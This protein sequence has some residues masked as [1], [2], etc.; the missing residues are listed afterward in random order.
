MCMSEKHSIPSLDGIRALAILAVV[1]GHSESPLFNH[2][3][4]DPFRNGSLGVIGFFVLSGFLITGILVRETDRAGGISLKRFY[5]RRA[6]R[7]FPAFY[8]YLIVIAILGVLRHVKLDLTSWLA[9]AT[10][11][12]N[13]VLNTSSYSLGQTWSLSLEE[14]FYLLW[15][16]CLVF[17]SKKTCFRIAVGSILLSPFSR[18]LTYALF[19]AF[20]GHINMMLHTHID[21]ILTGAALALA[22]NL[23]LFAK[24]RVRLANAWF[25]LPIGVY[26]AIHPMLANLYRGSFALPVGMTLD[27]IAW[28]IFVLHVTRFPQLPVG[29]FL[30]WA[31]I[32][33][34]GRISYSVY[35]WQQLF[36]GENQPNAFP[37]NL[38]WIFLCAEGSYW[39]IEQPF[40]RLRDRVVRSP[41][42][43]LLPGPQAPG[44]VAAIEQARN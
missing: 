14:Q 15:P 38:I 4:I 16:L 20:R 32:A 23:G 29:K 8:A 39:L 21:A 36:T 10:Y 22:Q 30:N 42:T 1:F 3:W 37:L 5:A 33:H 9:A 18:V 11:T 2:P 17:F 13:Y 19:P 43:E 24:L 25:L 27:E 28:A 31:P 40:L 34:I 12:W 35:L 26:F 7:I 41:E 6:F 44:E